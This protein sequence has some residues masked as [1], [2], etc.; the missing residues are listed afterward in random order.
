MEVPCMVNINTHVIEVWDED[1]LE[2]ETPDD[3]QDSVP[4]QLWPHTR[5]LHQFPDH[6]GAAPKAQQS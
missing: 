5:G 1:D 4:P 6:F 3:I 2:Y